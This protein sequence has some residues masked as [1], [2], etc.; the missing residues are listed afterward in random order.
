MRK[1]TASAVELSN[2][3]TSQNNMEL[4]RSFSWKVQ[5]AKYEPMYFFSSR[6]VECEEGEAA[7]KGKKL[8]A[9][10]VAEV[11]R[12]IEA[13]RL[14]KININDLPMRSIKPKTMTGVQQKISLKTEARKKEIGGDASHGVALD[15]YNNQ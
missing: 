4:A 8:I 7:K 11:E 13:Y 6:K 12:D 14:S 15:D 5:I 10:C 3:L 1:I 9:E 2:Q